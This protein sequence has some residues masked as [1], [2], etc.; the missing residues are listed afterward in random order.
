MEKSRLVV[1]ERDM[2]CP[3]CDTNS[4]VI[5]SETVGSKS[6]IGCAAIGI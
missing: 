1:I 6:R 3:Y 5:I 2:Y 4:A